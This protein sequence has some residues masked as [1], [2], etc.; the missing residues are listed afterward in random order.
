MILKLAQNGSFCVFSERSYFV[1]IFKDIMTFWLL[2]KYHI[3][4]RG[5]YKCEMSQKCIWLLDNSKNIGGEGA[6]NEYNSAWGSKRAQNQVHHMCFGALFL[7]FMDSQIINEGYIFSNKHKNWCLN[8]KNKKKFVQIFFK[9]TK[10]SKYGDFSKSS[11]IALLGPYLVKI[12]IA[13]K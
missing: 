10:K 13:L 2:L 3:T 1:L 4:G 9:R 11:K 7:A 8:S 6:R 12:D 5:V